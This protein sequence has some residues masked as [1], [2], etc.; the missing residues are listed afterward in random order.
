[1]SYNTEIEELRDQ[2]NDL[3]EEIID[4]ISE[5]IRTSKKNEKH[6]LHVYTLILENVDNLA[7]EYS[8]NSE[9]IER[10]FNA[11]QDLLPKTGRE[12]L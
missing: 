1:V 11:I 9:G 3:D 7:H 2:I 12:S 4:K 6:R 10:I 5:L 8:L